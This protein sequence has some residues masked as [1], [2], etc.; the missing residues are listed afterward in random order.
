MAS[1]PVRVECYSGHS[2]AQEPR[3]FTW[4][5][6]RHLVAAVERAWRTPSGPH[7]RVRTQDGARFELAYD[8]QTDEWE[9]NRI[10]NVP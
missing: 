2:Y 1:E 6:E 9:L 3:V 8:E 10:C 7:F 4:R 5:G